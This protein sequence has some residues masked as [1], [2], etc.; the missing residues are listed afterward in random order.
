MK[1]MIVEQE[2]WN[3]SY[4]I[5][6]FAR[7][8]DIDPTKQLIE[9]YIPFTKNNEQA[10]ELGCFPGRFL[11]EIGQKGYILNGCDLA[12]QIRK[13]LKGW[14]LKNNCRVNQ[15]Y[16]E[17]YLKFKNEQYDLV[18]SFGFIEHFKNYEEVFIQQCGMI[19]ENGILLVQFPNFRG[20]IQHRLHKIFDAYNLSNHVIGS[21]NLEQY[22]KL[23][24]NNFE[25][26][27]CSYYGNFDFWIDDFKKRNGKV[28][29]KLLK[30]LFKTSKFWEY[31]PNSSIYSP[32]AA[33]IAGK[34][35]K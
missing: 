18:A 22:R 35:S 32:Y 27:F 23:L 4:E 16:N 2:Y 13:E 20:A 28:K 17:P 6:K 34:K 21:M 9:R 14:C 5:Y 11:V 7:L 33:L 15:F 19:K 10:F 26:L 8:S 29:K 30:L 3:N 12:P 1:H 31:T 24:P 25:I